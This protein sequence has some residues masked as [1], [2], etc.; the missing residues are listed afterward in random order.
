LTAKLIYAASSWRGFCTVAELSRL[1]SVVRKAS[2]WG[3]CYERDNNMT[4]ILD[5]ADKDLFAKVLCNPHH[6]LQPL[7][8]PIKEPNYCLRPRGH[9][10]QLPKKTS[11]SARNF[12]TRMLYATV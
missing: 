7:L 4:A 9:L 1:D 11:L 5:N 6:V 3:L 8:P 12:F 10:H 2:R